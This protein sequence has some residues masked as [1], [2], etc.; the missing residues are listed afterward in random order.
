MENRKGLDY[1]MRD[2]V[3]IIKAVDNK[4]NSVLVIL[5]YTMAI[6]MIFFASVGLFIFMWICLGIGFLVLIYISTSPRWLLMDS[7]SGDIEVYEKHF[8]VPSGRIIENGEID[9]VVIKGMND[10]GEP[11][12]ISGKTEV[13]L[14][15]KLNN[16]K[17]LS[18]I[19]S[20]N[21]AMP[22]TERKERIFDM[23][24]AM[25]DCLSKTLHDFC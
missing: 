25:S 16:G 5:F 19:N 17:T 1:E 9:G 8:L 15:L 18:I 24:N 22:P 13:S 20:K 7:K 4:Y 11:G 21:I 12:S 10:K 6:S 23:G 2:N 3:L 14:G